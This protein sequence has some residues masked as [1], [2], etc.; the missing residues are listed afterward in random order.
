MEVPLGVLYNFGVVRSTAAVCKMCSYLKSTKLR[1]SAGL[2]TNPMIR[3]PDHI[4]GLEDCR[5]GIKV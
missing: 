2:C 4:A 3:S 1:L 5:D